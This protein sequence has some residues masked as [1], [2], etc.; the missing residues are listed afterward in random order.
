M[1]LAEIFSFK[2]ISELH[3]MASKQADEAERG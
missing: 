3:G 2:L 1:F